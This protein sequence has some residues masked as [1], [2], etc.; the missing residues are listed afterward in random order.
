[1]KKATV[2]ILSF[3]YLV[4][5]TGL[6][7]SVHY[8][9]GEVNSISFTEGIKDCSSCGKKAMKGCCKDQTSSYQLDNDHNGSIT[10]ISLKAPDLAKAFVHNFKY[11]LLD[12]SAPATE[13]FFTINENIFR[14]K[15][16]RFLIHCTF[17]I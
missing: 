9:G 7:M 5:S 13:S 6:T 10:K 14:D 16:P 15:N 4:F 12:Y 17:L 2:I 3:M 11:L 1:M 8:C